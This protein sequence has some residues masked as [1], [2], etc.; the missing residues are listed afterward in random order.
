MNIKPRVFKFKK[1]STRIAV[2][3]VL[4]MVIGM[5]ILNSVFSYFI[6]KDTIKLAKSELKNN[7]LHSKSILERSVDGTMRGFLKGNLNALRTQI[8]H[9]SDN[10]S[11]EEYLE[12]AKTFADGLKIGKDGYAYFLDMDGILLYHPIVPGMDV[13]HDKHM[14]QII[15]SRNGFLAYNNDVGGTVRRKLAQYYYDSRA[16]MV[17]AISLYKSEVLSLINFDELNE[18]ILAIKMGE[19]GT[20]FII[21]QKKEIILHPTIKEG[22]KLAK[23]ILESDIQKIMDIDE[24]GASIKYH[25]KNG[26]KRIAYAILWKD[27]DLRIVYTITEK[28]L[29]DEAN[30]LSNLGNIITLIISL[31]A[32][33]IFLFIGKSIAKPIILLKEQIGLLAEGRFDMSFSQ[34]RPDEV[35]KLSIDLDKFKSILEN[36]I[37]S[38]KLNLNKTVSS[39]RNLT[40]SL[41]ISVEGGKDAEGIKDLEEFISKVLDNVRDQTASSEES[42][43]ALEEVAA[44]NKV[45]VDKIKNNS[46]N[47]NT[48]FELI[49][50]SYSLT[51]DMERAILY[52][53]DLANNSSTQVGELA[54]NTKN[55]NRIITAINGISEQTNLLAL[56]AA[57]EAARAGEAGRGFS[58]VA[59]EIRKLADQ[60]NGETKKI[61]EII[62]GITK[63]VDETTKSSTD[64]VEKVEEITQSTT[65]LAKINNKIKSLTEENT[66]EV[67]EIKSGI[68]EMENATNEITKAISDITNGSCEIES[69]MTQS[70]ELSNKLKNTLVENQTNVKEINTDLEELNQ[71]VDFFKI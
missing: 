69:K 15:S 67:R 61:E 2:S 3:G 57:I 12:R 7:A 62:K 10:L 52:A 29:F 28:D 34:N 46:E 9:E 40:E 56:N 4:L 14:Q 68:E 65:E 47:L 21:N 24:N 37:V 22:E 33:L 20:P 27:L 31:I 66:S 6:R 19:S 54:E 41:K 13:S 25:L 16:N 1:L 53:K 45:L 59:E 63:K 51:E 64:V 58:V 26:D 32:G 43:A 8:E 48:T 35:G 17:V 38:M 11:D 44:T 36:I 18:K 71:K 49:E 39:N 70:S 60:T 23:H 50:S 55:I 30:K 5:I 42:L